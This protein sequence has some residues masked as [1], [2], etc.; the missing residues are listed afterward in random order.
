MANRN[1]KAAGNTPGKF[2]VDNSCCDCDMCRNTAPTIFT[3]NDET[4]VTI[5]TRQPATPDEIVLV[6]SALTECPVDSIGAD[7]EMASAH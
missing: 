4:G 1:D 5:V 7:G 6:E 2:Y 3:R